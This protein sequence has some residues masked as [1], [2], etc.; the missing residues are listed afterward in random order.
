MELTECVLTRKS[1]RAFKTTPVPRE[2]LTRILDEAKRCASAANT[3]PWEFAVFGGE[4][5]EE[6]RMAYRERALSGSKP[7]AEIPYD[8]MAWPEP[9]RT[10]REEN[11]RR[12]YLSMQIERDDAEQRKQFGLRGYSFFGAPNGIIIYINS[13]LVD[14]FLPWAILDVGGILQTILLLAHNYGLGCCPQTQMV[15]YPDIIRKVMNI[16]SAK[17]IIVGLAIGYPD[18]HDRINKYV[19]DRLPFEEMVTWYGI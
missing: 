9:Y 2:L 14:S 10:R 6:M 18:E 1:I 5:I 7:N 19:S 12:M 16:P 13:V 11:G 17:K 8:P 15:Y 3:Q 4:V